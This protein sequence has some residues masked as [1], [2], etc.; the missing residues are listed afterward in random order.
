MSWRFCFPVFNDDSVV[1]KLLIAE[2]KRRAQINPLLWNHG[3]KL[4]LAKVYTR[5]KIGPRR[6]G[7]NQGETKR[8]GDVIWAEDSGRD[9]IWAEAGANKANPCD[10]FGMLKEN[11]DDLTIVEGSP[12]IGK[13]TFCL[14]LAYEWANQSSSADSFPVFELVLLLKCRD[15]D[16]DLTEAIT[17]QLFPKD[18]SKDCLL[19]TS[20]SPRDLSTSRMPSSA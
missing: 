18:M 10:V 8:W 19:Y 14:E 5:L 12:G 7:G 1:V 11:K 20:P 16:G 17:D 6:R 15:I 13:T 3:V 9:E 4:P 2:Y